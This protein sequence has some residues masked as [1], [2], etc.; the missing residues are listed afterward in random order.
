M[1]DRPLIL[2]DLEAVREN[3]L[4]LSDDI[5]L[6]IDHNDPESLEEGVAFKR[7]YNEKLGAFDSL[8]TE[9][10]TLIQQFT[11]VNLASEEQTGGDSES[12]NRRIIQE[13][14]RD[15]AHSLDENFTY[16]RPHGFILNGVDLRRA[17]DVNPLICSR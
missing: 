14:D 13:L 17:G 2:E 4:A 16:K 9:L 12:E 3:L 11:S 6:S 5:W 1:T 15:E 10:S 8:A 7:T